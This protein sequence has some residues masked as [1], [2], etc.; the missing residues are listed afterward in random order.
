M[1]EVRAMYELLD[2]RDK[3]VNNMYL[4]NAALKR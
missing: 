3:Q 4:S 1:Q 2:V